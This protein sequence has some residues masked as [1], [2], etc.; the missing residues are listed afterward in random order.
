MVFHLK[1]HPKKNVERMMKMPHLRKTFN[2]QRK[3]ILVQQRKVAVKRKISQHQKI[4][5]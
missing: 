4:K 5:G 2:Y 1:N 3:F